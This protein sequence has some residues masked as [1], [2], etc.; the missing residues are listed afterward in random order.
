MTVSS[1]ARIRAGF[2]HYVGIQAYNVR[3][4]RAQEILGEERPVHTAEHLASA[5]FW[6]GVPI[7]TIPRAKLVANHPSPREAAARAVIHPFA[8]LPEKT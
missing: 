5:M 3:I 4:P 2:G 7:R 8:S 6:L 1:G